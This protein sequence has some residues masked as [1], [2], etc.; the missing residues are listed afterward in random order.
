[1]IFPSQEGLKVSKD[2]KVE[3]SFEELEAG[4]KPGEAFAFS[5]TIR[6]LEMEKKKPWR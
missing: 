6:L 5:A 4:F 3:E 1:M 2:L